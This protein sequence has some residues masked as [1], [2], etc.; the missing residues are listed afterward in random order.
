M[1]IHV[2]REVQSE[3]ELPPRQGRA[4]GRRTTGEKK[5]ARF[6]LSLA[7]FRLKRRKNTDP[8]LE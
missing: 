3:T 7:F 5:Q 6:A 2:V 4:G 1:Q 8:N